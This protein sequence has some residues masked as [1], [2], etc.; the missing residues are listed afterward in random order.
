MDTIKKATGPYHGP[1]SADGASRWR[2]SVLTDDGKRTMRGFDD[3]ESCAAF[4]AA[5]GGTPRPNTPPKRIGPRPRTTSSTVH[6]V[7]TKP[8][9]VEPEG[10]GSAY[11]ISLLRAS[12]EELMGDPGQDALKRGRVLA[13]LAT[14]ARG[15][16]DQL[17]YEQ[18]VEQLEGQLESMLQAARYGTE[19]HPGRETA[20]DRTAS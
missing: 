9:Q 1:A 19:A 20:P 6:L 3:Y 12:A 18:R 10:A 4:V 14:S 17:Q 11:W 8:A 7:R 13:A 5:H 15:H 2:C 16:Q